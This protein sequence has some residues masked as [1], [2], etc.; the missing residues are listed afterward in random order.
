MKHNP[1]SLNI[2]FFNN[3]AQLPI[4][5]QYELYLQQSGSKIETTKSNKQSRSVKSSSQVVVIPKLRRETAKKVK[6]ETIKV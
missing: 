6:Q 2:G 5:H 1:L 4:F 3:F